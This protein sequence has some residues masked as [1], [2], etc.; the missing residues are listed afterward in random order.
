MGKPFYYSKRL[1]TSG[2]IAVGSLFLT[3]AFAQ[4]EL[5]YTGELGLSI[6]AAHYF[7]DLN[8]R[9]AINAAKPSI[10]I[11]YR[12]YMNDYVG[13]RFHGRFMQIG[14]SDIYNKNDFQRR[15]NLSFNS[16][17]WELGVQGD[18]N[19]FR[20]EPGSQIYRF[21][22][23]FTGGA[24]LFYF[25]PYAYL[26]GR[27]Y[28]LQPLGT[29]GQG[30]AMYPDRKPYGLVNYAFL[31]GGGFKYNVSKKVNVGLEVLYRFTQTDYLDDVST[32]YAG[33]A[34]FPPDVNGNPSVAYILQDRSWATGD[35]IGTQGRQRGNSRD[36]DQIATVELTIS[37][38][39][40]SYRCKF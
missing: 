35:L 4:N 30:T 13:V 11:F 5:S 26:N 7:G 9:G 37:I 39:F 18:F 15:R 36:K 24:S 28:R 23:Y 2:L 14:Y 32:T 40:T 25:N 22:P 27:K 1:I 34:A 29:E 10:G 17:V 12:K 38:L 16:N 8:T 3:P 33:P 31:V 21:T 19:F 6:G 20:F